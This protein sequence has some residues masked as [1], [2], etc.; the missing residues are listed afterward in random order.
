MN[1]PTSS[2]IAQICAH[3][4]AQCDHR[5]RGAASRANVSEPTQVPSFNRVGGNVTCYPSPS[6]RPVGIDGGPSFFEG[7]ARFTIKER[8]EARA[9][10]EFSNLLRFAQLLVAFR[11]VSP[12]RILTARR[13]APLWAGLA[14]RPLAA[15]SRPALS[16][17][18]PQG[19][20]ATKSSGLAADLSNDRRASARSISDVTGP[21][22]A[23]RPWWSF[24]VFTPAAMAGA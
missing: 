2:G 15:V 12:R 14:R 9:R 7:M 11:A 3:T 17:G 8:E 16:Q 13:S 5:F 22:G 18:R 1:L 6:E 19:R 10:C 24:F 21:S 4:F 23:D 20:F